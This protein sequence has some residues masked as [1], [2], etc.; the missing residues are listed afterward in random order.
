MLLPPLAPSNGREPLS[1]GGKEDETKSERTRIETWMA[2]L[3][4]WTTTT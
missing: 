2:R 1:A 3:Q 4:N